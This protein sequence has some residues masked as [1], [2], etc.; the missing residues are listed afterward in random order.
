MKTLQGHEYE[1]RSLYVKEE[2]L[3][4]GGYDM[5]IKVWNIETLEL[6]HTITGLNGMLFHIFNLQDLHF[7]CVR[8]KENCL[9]EVG[10]VI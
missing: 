3:F 2:K 9:L 4:S 8:L 10:H 1:V 6:L 5:T 7:P